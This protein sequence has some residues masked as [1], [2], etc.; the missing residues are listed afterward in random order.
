MDSEWSFIYFLIIDSG[1]INQKKVQLGK[2]LHF[3]F[4]QR[5]WKKNQF[6]SKNLDINIYLKNFAKIVV[7]PR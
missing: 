7:Q 3:L 2:M 5:A 1:L 4:V 6:F